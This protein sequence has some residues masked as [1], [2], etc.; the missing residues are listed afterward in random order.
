MS[1]LYYVIPVPIGFFIFLCAICLRLASRQSRQNSR[2][3]QGWVRRD[4]RN[5]RVIRRMIIV[6]RQFE[7]ATTPIIPAEHQ[8][9]DQP[10]PN[11]PPPSYESA[12][13]QQQ[14]GAYVRAM[15]G[16]DHQATASSPSAPRPGEQPPS[17]NP[18][19]MVNPNN[20]SAASHGLLLDVASLPCASGPQPHSI[21]K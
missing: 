11:D 20:A 21:N 8:Y 1:E 4:G 9:P 5:V 12:A 15:E 13:A 16:W 17:Y 10:H 3:G 18:Q 2:C 14:H 19:P 7:S 6:P